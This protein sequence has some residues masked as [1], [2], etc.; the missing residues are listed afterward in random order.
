MKPR[1]S[2]EEIADSLEQVV[3]EDGMRLVLSDLQDERQKNKAQA[4]RIEELEADLKTVL[5]QNYPGRTAMHDKWGL[6]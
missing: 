5:E 2:D 3:M 1:V 4:K 6:P